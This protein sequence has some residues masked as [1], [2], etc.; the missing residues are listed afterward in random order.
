MFRSLNCWS[1]I[2]LRK[3]IE[4]SKSEHWRNWIA[5]CSL[6][7]KWQNVVTWIFL[8]N[9]EYAFKCCQKLLK[10][11]MQQTL[12]TFLR[13]VIA[14]TIGQKSQV[15]HGYDLINVV[16]NWFCNKSTEK[17]PGL[18]WYASHTMHHKLPHKK[19]AY[20]DC[21]SFL[22]FSMVIVWKVCQP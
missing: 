15:T 22:F 11:K 4:F 19:T 1:L 21:I 13:S 5:H 17:Q 10:S 16:C 2:I 8:S 6:I 12:E 18:T 20:S 3:K 7:T 9:S 14:T